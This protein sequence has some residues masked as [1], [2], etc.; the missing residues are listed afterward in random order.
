M[1]RT[2]TIADSLHNWIQK[3]RGW[4]LHEHQIDLSYTAA[5]N[6]YLALGIGQAL[7]KTGKELEDF[8]NEVMQSTEIDLAS[9]QDEADNLWLAK[10]LPKIM[11]KI[12][13]N[14]IEK[15]KEK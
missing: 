14:E 12:N 2:V 8:A 15:A 10:E 13:K 7:N 11:E 4:Y 5:L 3:I 1:R 9:I 6:W